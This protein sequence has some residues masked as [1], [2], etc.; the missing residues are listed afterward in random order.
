MEQADVARPNRP[1]ARAPA[2]AVLAGLVLA[3]T[4]L[5]V[6]SGP[7]SATA[8][9]CQATTVVAASVA[10]SWVDEDSPLANKGND[11]ILAVRAGEAPVPG[12][13][14]L[15]RGRALIHFAL[16]A[17]VPAGCIIES[18]RLMLFTP[19]D[20]DG[21]R[22]DVLR[23]ASAWT[24]RGVTWS[25]QP[26]AVGTPVSA[27]TASGYMQ[28]SVTAHVQ[29]MIGAPH[30]GFLIRDSAEGTDAGGDHSF[31]SREKDDDGP[32]QLVIRFAP[33]PPP[34]PPPA[35]AAPV[36]A[37]VSCGQVLTRSTLLTN[38]LAE[39][40]GDGL[41]IGAPRLIVDLGGHVVDGTGLGTGIRVDGYASV[42]VRNGTVQEFD[43]GVGL[44]PDTAGSV[45]ESLTLRL[46]QLSG[47]QLFDAGAGNVIRNNA[48]HDNGDGIALLSGTS[49]AVVVGNSVVRNSGNGLRVR[50][51]DGNRLEANRVSDGSD[52]GID[53][54]RASGNTVLANT[55][56]ANSDGAIE[57]RT[58]SAGNR[59]ERNTL[60]DSGDTGILVAESDRNVIV[61][62]ASHGMSDSGIS[63]EAANDGVVRGNDLRFN[64]GGLQ[65]DGASRN[66][67]EGNNASSTTGIGI[68]V[69][70][71][72]Y[73]NRLVRNTT[74]ANGAQGIYLGDEAQTEPGNVV[75]ANTAVANRSDG[76]VA[77]KGGHRLI[78][79]VARS[80]AGWGIHA[81]PGTIDGGLNVAAGNGKPEQCVGVVCRPEWI[82]PQTTIGSRP[83][84]S[85]RST[86]ATFTFTSSEVGSRFQCSLGTAAFTSCGSP[87]TYTGLTAG[88]HRFRVRAIDPAGN[89][90]A[91]PATVTWTVDLTAPQT[92][93]TARPPAS[94]TSRSAT[95]RFTSSE[96][97]SRFQCSLDGAAYA[98]CTSP[99]T[100]AGLTVRAHSFRVRAVDAAGNVDA[101][102]ATVTWTVRAS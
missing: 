64:P 41:V 18:A 2:A 62:N 56:S 43:H 102:P 60:T 7:G 80:N 75:E 69:G 100:Y 5:P 84:V 35:P 54:E 45:V 79:N 74:S 8:A 53:L 25:N 98:G 37:A 83:P 82:P 49:G 47:L 3:L 63:L 72:S 1:R 29:A 96:A 12:A 58:G 38:D 10:D 17:S 92:T 15:G 28:W 23:A 27:W 78:A 86:S 67:V 9:T 34:G 97:G 6:G 57:I 99:R 11:A 61:S 26:A 85:T 50:D 46:N 14:S 73:G 65:L 36:P 24:E 32:P 22:A 48:V 101:S 13:A 70:G 40:P 20:G 93:I 81:A 30:H 95:F 42:T 59:V 68:E 91:T 51:S 71:G 89:V 77:A 19:E 31:H 90:D 76:I 94:T 16:P 39:C 66:L 55:V 21:T 52:I 33:P 88:N 44:A 87:R 4:S